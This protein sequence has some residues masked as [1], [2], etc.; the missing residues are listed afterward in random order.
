LGYR[1]SRF[2]R[3]FTLIIL[4]HID[5]KNNIPGFFNSFLPKFLL[6]KLIYRVKSEKSRCFSEY[7]GVLFGLMGIGRFF[8][9]VNCVMTARGS[10]VLYKNTAMDGGGRGSEL[11]NLP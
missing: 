11:G 10:V 5:K 1:L 4:T 8:L 6:F 2:N 7:L 3:H 9:A